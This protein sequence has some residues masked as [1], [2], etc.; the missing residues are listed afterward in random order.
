MNMDYLS[1]SLHHDVWKR[2]KIYFK[3][4]KKSSGFC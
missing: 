1:I 4:K 2:F 3:E